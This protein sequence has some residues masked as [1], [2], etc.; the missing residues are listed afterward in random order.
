M[1]QLMTFDFSGYQF[2]VYIYSYTSLLKSQ[3]FVID[4]FMYQTWPIKVW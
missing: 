3:I 2:L 4:F 1:K